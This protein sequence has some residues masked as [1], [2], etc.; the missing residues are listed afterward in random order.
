M[1]CHDVVAL[2]GDGLVFRL[3]QPRIDHQHVAFRD[4]ALGETA[5]NHLLQRTDNRNITLHCIGEQLHGRQIPIGILRRI[6]HFKTGEFLVAQCD[7]IT[8]FGLPIGRSRRTTAVDRLHD[9]RFDGKRPPL[10]IVEPPHGNRETSGRRQPRQ[11]S[12][13]DAAHLLDRFDALFRGGFQLSAVCCH[14]LAILLHRNLS[15]ISR[16]RRF[17]NRK[18]RRS[19]QDGNDANEKNKRFHD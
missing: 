8:Q 1:E 14:R 16:P 5:V 9:L 12:R 11:K 18:L 2:G 13:A 17:C 10:G 6:T 7:A 15:R 19:P 3:A 4:V